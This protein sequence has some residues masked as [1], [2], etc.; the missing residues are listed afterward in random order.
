MRDRRSLVEA[1]GQECVR[2]AELADEGP[3]GER[4]LQFTRLTVILLQA[5][6]S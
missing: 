4:L 1:P 2:G 3:L 5:G 6:G